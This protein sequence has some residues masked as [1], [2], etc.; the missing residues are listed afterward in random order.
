MRAGDTVLLFT[1]GLIERRGED[2]DIGQKRVLQA[3]P[4]LAGPDIDAALGRLV[5]S[6][7]EP[8]LD[9]DVAAVVARRTR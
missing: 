6:L 9:D 7:R 4:M 5:V 1:D 2:I 3:L 8:A